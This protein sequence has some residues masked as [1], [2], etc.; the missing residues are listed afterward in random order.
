MDKAGLK[1]V[2]SGWRMISSAR[3]F[4]HNRKSF[5]F[6]KLY[7]PR[8]EEAAIAKRIAEKYGFVPTLERKMGVWPSP[9]NLTREEMA[10]FPVNVVLRVPY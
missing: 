2:R 6:L 9:R 10:L 5:Y 1:K 8:A 4:S 7:R 3:I